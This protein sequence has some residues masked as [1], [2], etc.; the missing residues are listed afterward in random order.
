MRS[1]IYQV[2]AS[3]DILDTSHIPFAVA[4]QPLADIGYDEVRF[5]YS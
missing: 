5:Y 3:K 4:I 2:A 1:T